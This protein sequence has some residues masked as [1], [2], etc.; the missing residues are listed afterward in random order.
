MCAL[1]P[2]AQRKMHLLVKRIEL[3]RAIERQAKDAIGK[4]RQDRAGFRH[5]FL[6]VALL[7]E[8]P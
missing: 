4:C 1:E 2:G 6:P 8:R 3:V 5:V 7:P